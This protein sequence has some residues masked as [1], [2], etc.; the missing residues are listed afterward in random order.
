MSKREGCKN[1]SWIGCKT[2]SEGE[3][4]QYK[5]RRH[6]AD[7]VDILAPYTLFFY[8]RTFFYKNVEVE[9]SPKF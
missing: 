3:V 4:I 6:L 2:T 1:T 8:I 7:G 5:L 9:I